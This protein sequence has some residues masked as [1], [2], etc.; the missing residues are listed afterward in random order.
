MH[1]NLIT[2]CRISAPQLTSDDVLAKCRA[3]AEQIGQGR[4]RTTRH[5]R[6][7]ANDPGLCSKGRSID[8]VG[9]QAA[10]RSATAAT[11][12]EQHGTWMLAGGTSLDGDP[13]S[14]AVVVTVQSDD[15]HVWTAF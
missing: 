15:V 3:A 1:E 14:V 6:E 10:L 2:L 13:L 9:F 7:K 8:W 4:I 5:S 11:W 12:Q